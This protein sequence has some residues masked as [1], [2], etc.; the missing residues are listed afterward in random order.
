MHWTTLLAATATAAGVIAGSAHSQVFDDEALDDLLRTE[1]RFAVCVWS[2]HMPLS[3]DAVHESVR[4][5]AALRVR[6]ISVLDPRADARYAASIAS[7]A[8]LPPESLRVAHAVRLLEADAFQHAPTVVAFANGHQ[9]GTAI[10]GYMN[11]E[12]YVDVLT[13][14]FEQEP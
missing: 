7:S 2:P 10:R 13:R 11:A 1:P 9:A 3:V 5:A 8:G 6:V 14:R 4:A 12:A